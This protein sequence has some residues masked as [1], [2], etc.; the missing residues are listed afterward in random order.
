VS[1]AYNINAI[2]SVEKLV[3][4]ESI[5]STDRPVLLCFCKYYNVDMSIYGQIG[6]AKDNSLIG[7]IY[8]HV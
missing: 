5:L 8:I 4:L 6:N 7:L 3:S 2:V 1:V